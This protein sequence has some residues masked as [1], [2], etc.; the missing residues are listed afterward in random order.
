[1]RPYLVEVLSPLIVLFLG[2][3]QGPKPVLAQ[4]FIAELSI[5]AFHKSVLVRLP[6][7]DKYLAGSALLD[8]LE[9]GHASK[10]QPVA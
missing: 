3:L 7:L 1:M 4:A 6:R 2:G 10:F 8:R 5:Q 9:H